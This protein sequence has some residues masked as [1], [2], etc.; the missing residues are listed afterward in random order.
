MEDEIFAQADGVH[1]VEDSPERIEIMREKIKRGGD[2]PPHALHGE[3]VLHDN[4]RL[5]Y[6]VNESCFPYFD[7]YFD[8]SVC[9]KVCP[10]NHAPYEKLKERKVHQAI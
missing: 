2:G 10:F 9:V 5:T 7:D 1:L 3:P 4:G 6:V 8:C